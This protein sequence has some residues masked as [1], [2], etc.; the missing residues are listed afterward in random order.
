MSVGVMEDYKLRDLR[1]PF[2]MLCP[3]TSLSSGVLTWQPEQC[4][5]CVSFTD[6]VFVQHMCLPGVKR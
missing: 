2:S 6:M 3:R 1:E 5:D 4:T